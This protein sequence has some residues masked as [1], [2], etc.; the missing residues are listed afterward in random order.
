VGNNRTSSDPD[1]PTSHGARV[2]VINSGDEDSIASVRSA[3][4]GS[5]KAVPLRVVPALGQAS[6]N[7]AKELSSLESKEVCHVLHDDVARS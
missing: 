1:P 7:L 2:G 5:R 6:E 4:G 3:E